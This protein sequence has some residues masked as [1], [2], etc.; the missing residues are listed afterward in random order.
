MTCPYGKISGLR[1]N[2]DTKQDKTKPQRYLK[3]CHQSNL[4]VKPVSAASIV[5]SSRQ[6][7]QIKSS[8]FFTV[9]PENPSKTPQGEPHVNQNQDMSQSL[10]REKK[11]EE[12][13][14]VMYLVII[15]S[16]QAELLH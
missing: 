2:G 1:N 9:A 3:S 10:N 15:P 14:L 11:T 4:F 5:L 6:K 8:C 16:N 12:R 7:E 13:I